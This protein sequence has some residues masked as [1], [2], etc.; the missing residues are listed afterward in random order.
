PAVADAIAHGSSA[1]D[2]RDLAGEA[3]I[4]P[5]ALHYVS[6]LMPVSRTG[7]SAL[8][9]ISLVTTRP[10][11][12]TRRRAAFAKCRADPHRPAPKIALWSV[13]ASQRRRDAL[14]LF[15]AFDE[16]V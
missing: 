1:A 13:P 5:G 4:L 14:G 9:R 8:G 15:D 12:L 2:D 3:A 6:P 7:S 10:Q 16:H 11:L